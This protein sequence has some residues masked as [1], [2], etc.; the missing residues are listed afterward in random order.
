MGRKRGTGLLVFLVILLLLVNYSWINSFAVKNVSD[1]D[2]GTV[3]RVIDGD[4]IV[5]GNES[6][7]LLGINTPEKG[8]EY[9]SEAKIF[10]ENIVLNKKIVLEKSKENRDKYGRLL[11]YVF[12]GDKNV[13]LEL[14]EAG[15]ANAYFPSGKDDYSKEFYSAWDKCVTNNINLCEKSTDKCASCFEVSGIRT[16]QQTI[17]LYNKCPFDCN[18][19][20][21]TIKGEGRKITQLNGII[22]GETET[23]LA[24]ENIWAK[25][26]DTL[27]L[28]DG[29]E[30][31]V[32]YYHY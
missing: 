23:R 1:R 4:T 5:V 11:R 8:E 6:V 24:T 32:L 3:L 14:I 25:V 27:F 9:Y 29:D 21:W 19:E 10:L 22:S 16:N 13:N 15:F 7:R 2:V 28:R 17:T 30:K 18:L 20:K 12:V 26:T 31:L